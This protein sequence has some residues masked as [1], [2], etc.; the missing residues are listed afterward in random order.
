M[1]P[2]QRNAFIKG[3]GLIMPHGPYLPAESTA[4]ATTET[5]PTQT[6]KAS[7]ESAGIPNQGQVQQGTAQGAA[8]APAQDQGGM[9][10]GPEQRA[11]QEAELARRAGQVTPTI[12]PSIRNMSNTSGSPGVMGDQIKNAI[13]N[14]PPEYIKPDGTFDQERYHRDNVKNP[15]FEIPPEYIKADGTFDQ[16]RYHRDHVKPMASQGGAGTSPTSAP[17]TIEES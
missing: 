1:T 12:T 11:Q 14:I 6:S 10:Y 2:E 15:I 8:Q 3:A 4:P 7:Q 13:F 17:Q 16:E 5:R 9:H